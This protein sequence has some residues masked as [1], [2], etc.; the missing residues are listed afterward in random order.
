MSYLVKRILRPSM[1]FCRFCAVASSQQPLATPETLPQPPS[2]QPVF[3]ETPLPTPSLDGSPKSYSPKI[4]SLVDQISSLT[5]LEVADLNELLKTT[6]GLPDIAMAAPVGAGPV[7]PGGADNAIAE[8]AATEEKGEKLVFNVKLV[9][10]DA[11]NKV[12]LIKEMKSLIE[13]MNLVQAKKFVEGA[14]Q[15]IMSDI[16]K[17]KAESIKKRVEAAGG[18]VEID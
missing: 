6:L 13:G 14:P 9:K 3:C 4:T 7:A 10:F 12:K 2:E 16:P 8:G 5:L 18:T 1:T 17:D 15:M 11:E